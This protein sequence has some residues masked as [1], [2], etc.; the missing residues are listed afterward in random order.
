MEDQI[1]KNKR[2]DRQLRIW[3]EHGQARLEACKVCLLH[4]G[5]TGAEAVKNLVLGGIQS[6]TL[7]DKAVVAPRDLGNNF[8]VEAADLGT[9]KAKAVAALLKELNSSV[10]GSFVDEA[11]EDIIANDPAFFKDFTVVVATQMASA[12]AAALDAI[13]RE[14]GVVLV[15]LRSYGLAGT[16]RLSL[17]EHAVIE[18]KPEES[19]FDLRLSHPWPALW[20]FAQSF[21][22]PSLDDAT[23]KHVPY[24]VL[25]LQA[26]HS[27][28]G[29]EE[30]GGTAPEGT[31]AQRAFKDQIRS[32]QRTHDEENFREAA[33]AAR[34]VWKPLTVPSNVRDLLADPALE[35]LTA[36]SPD[37]WFKVAGLG[38]F[39]TES[40]GAMPLEGS[41]PDMTSTTEVYIA[42]QR[43]YQD[44]AAADAEAVHGH[45]RA[46][47]RGAGRA[48]DSVSAT[49]VRFFCKHAAHLRVLRWRTLAEEVAWKG[50]AGSE[51]A[52]QLADEDTQSCAALYV[53]LRAADA[54]EAMYDRLPG[55]PPTAAGPGSKMDANEVV[56]DVTRLKCIANGILAEIG[57][58]S[59]GVLDDLTTEVVRSGGGE[60]HA[61]ASVV[62]GVGSQEIIKLVTRQFVPCGKT[63]VYNAIDSTT[64]SIM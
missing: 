58:G 19:D 47:L 1:P 48:E 20:D 53:L 61:V 54:F 9:S 43:V 26:A 51:L 62:G 11:P 44:K 55:A 30:N 14:H 23:F 25:L 60:L 41:I 31:K 16:V 27:W 10:A 32:A 15:V 42:L 52:R 34:H 17:G 18:A 64:A 29:A 12:P 57:V 33:G 36:S 37:F 8:M 56:V 35:S 28:R 5:P 46:A 7:V 39:L 13:C 22:L 59:L 40:G 63:L 49:E 50:G 38:A 21:D 4:C 2:Y 6:F 3:G 45:V 24:V